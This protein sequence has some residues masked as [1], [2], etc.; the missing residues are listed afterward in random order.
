MY[1]FKDMTADRQQR[2]L[3]HLTQLLKAC[4]IP[5]IDSISMHLDNTQLRLD[6][7]NDYHIAIRNVDKMEPLEIVRELISF[8]RLKMD[9]GEIKF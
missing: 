8:V 2:F 1:K 7:M 3:F 5:W 9:A 4:G 6:F